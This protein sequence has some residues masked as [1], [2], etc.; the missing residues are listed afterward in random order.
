VAPQV[1]AYY[2]IFAMRIIAYLL[3]NLT[4][5]QVSVIFIAIEGLLQKSNIYIAKLM[6]MSK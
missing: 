1:G 3:R 5:W 4:Q 2:T 6:P